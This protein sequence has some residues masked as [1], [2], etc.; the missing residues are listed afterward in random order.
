MRSKEA[1]ENLSLLVA[2]QMAGFVVLE[3]IIWLLLLLG[4]MPPTLVLKNM[5]AVV[6][7]INSAYLVIAGLV[8]VLVA[9]FW[10]ALLSEVFGLIE[11]KK[12]KFKF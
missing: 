2:I 8:S 1:F 7:Q 5:G 11:I 6:I 4:I 10:V 9:G 12:I 3:L